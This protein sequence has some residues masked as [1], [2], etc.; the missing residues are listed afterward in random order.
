[1]EVAIVTYCK[2]PTLSDTYFPPDLRDRC[3][4]FLGTKGHGKRL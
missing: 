2:L 3:P 4:G 1:M